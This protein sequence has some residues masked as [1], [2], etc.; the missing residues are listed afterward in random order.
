MDDSLASVAAGLNALE[1]RLDVAARNLAGGRTP[2]FVPKLVTT[3]SF[4]GEFVDALRGGLVTAEEGLDLAP[5]ELVPSSN[6]L[7]VALRGQGY[8]EVAT[9]DGKAYTRGGD[10]E[11]VDGKLA[12]RAGYAVQGDAGDLALVPGGGRPR[13]SPDGTVLQDGAPLGRLKVVAFKRPALLEAVGDT[14]LRPKENAD[15]EPEVVADAAF[16]PG[17]IEIPAANAVSG[18]VEMITVHR[19]YDAAQRA[20]T[21]IHEAYERI[22]RPQG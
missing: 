15:A 16:A 13:L 14:L 9:P 22:L 3:R 18:L 2:G 19:S 4:E 8:F 7:A 1:R 12:T 11:I 17:M 20:A 6:P 10:F 5:G 21:S